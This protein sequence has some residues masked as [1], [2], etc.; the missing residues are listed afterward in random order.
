[1]FQRPHKELYD[2]LS[3]DRFNNVDALNELSQLKNEAVDFTYEIVDAFDDGKI[4]LSEL[5]TKTEKEIGE[6]V[7]AMEVIKNTT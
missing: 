5:A 7:E 6:Y 3:L 4:T 2:S 1:M